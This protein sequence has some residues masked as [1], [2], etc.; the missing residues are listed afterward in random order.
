MYF[1]QVARLT[2]T[3]SLMSHFSIHTRISIMKI[4][5]NK[6]NKKRLMEPF[7]KCCDYLQSVYV[8]YYTIVGKFDITFVHVFCHYGKEGICFICYV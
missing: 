8:L 6:I 2:F 4:V 7:C 3:K 1:V 5:A